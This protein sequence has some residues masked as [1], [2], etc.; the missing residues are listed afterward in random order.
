[1]KQ[2]LPLLLLAT[3]LATTIQAQHRP[4]P[5]TP[6]CMGDLP[7]IANGPQDDG[8]AVPLL[9]LSR[10][11]DWPSGLGGYYS[12]YVYADMDFP[13]PSTIGADYYVPQVK[14]EGQWKDVVY[15]DTIYTTTSYNYCP[16]IEFSNQAYRLRIVGG[17]YDGK[18]SNV[19]EVK[20][21]AIPAS[22]GCSWTDGEN[23]V[24][25]PIEAP[26]VG[27][28]RVYSYTDYTSI[29]NPSQ[30]LN[31]KWYRRNPY[32]YSLTLIE[33]ATGD[34]YTPTTEDIGYSIIC[35][36]TGDGQ[37]FD[38]TLRKS[39]PDVIFFPV[40][41][42]P[43]YQG[44]D[45]VIL[46]TE[47][48]LPDPNQLHISYED[49][50]DNW[51]LKDVAA[52]SIV[53][54]APGRYKIYADLSELSDNYMTI[55][56]GDSPMVGLFSKYG[57]DD[58]YVMIRETQLFLYGIEWQ[59]TALEG[60]APTQA[61]IEV[62]RYNIDGELYVSATATIDHDT[63]WISLPMGKCYLRTKP[64]T[65]FMQT[66]YP[67]AASWSDATMLEVPDY[68]NYI[69]VY[70]IQMLPAPAPLTGTGIIEGT[71]ARNSQNANALR[72]RAMA[73]SEEWDVNMLLINNEG[74]I[75]ATV[76]VDANGHFKFEN[77]PFG[78]YTV[79]PDAAGYTVQATPVTVS[80]EHPT[81]TEVDYT[82]SNNGIV[83]AGI[84]AIETV[85]A[86]GTV[87]PTYDLFGRRVRAASPATL[88]LRHNQKILLR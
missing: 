16:Y 13:S 69:D 45:G 82:V 48:V 62:L 68:E 64:T 15:D 33:G 21:P 5:V 65:S 26:S 55:R 31:Y 25:T 3:L 28:V 12:H 66:Y 39:T 8:S 6:G 10:V 34:T 19:I 67:S 50:N 72:N 79:R 44:V 14:S 78:T 86:P 27:E 24:G 71:I 75:I 87:A 40:Y 88:Q 4:N 17:T 74:H 9:E 84:T 22:Y 51:K 18:F 60:E 37:H 41:C 29:E 30:Y 85:S 54:E 11:Y 20:Y 52:T 49:Y 70:A 23:I 2:T 32:N 61:E 35:E 81:V 73:A 80:A 42:S 36:V 83:P 56:Y 59:V 58:E 7:T 57:R 76:Q 47:Y 63:A 1:M 46:N 53:T 38:L 43:D 77:V